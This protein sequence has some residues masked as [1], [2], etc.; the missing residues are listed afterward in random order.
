VET[1]TEV[2]RIQRK[3]GKSGTFSLAMSRH[4]NLPAWV[5]MVSQPTSTTPFD[6]FSNHYIEFRDKCQTRNWHVFPI[7]N[8]A[9]WARM[10][11]AGACALSFPP[12]PMRESRND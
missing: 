4:N 7:D 10:A 2:W 11:I 12:R 5:N 8:L 6:V 9:A 3:R 1:S